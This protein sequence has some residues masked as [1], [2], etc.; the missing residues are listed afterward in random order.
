LSH[1]HPSFAIRKLVV[2]LHADKQL[3]KVPL[4]SSHS[5][6]QVSPEQQRIIDNKLSQAFAHRTKE[7]KDYRRIVQQNQQRRQQEIQDSSLVIKLVAVLIILIIV[8]WYFV[9]TSKTISEYMKSIF[10]II[11]KG[12][13]SNF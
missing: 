6:P 3:P 12:I 1:V 13:S 10:F 4:N 5:N 11:F 9:V 2:S 7:A 8:T